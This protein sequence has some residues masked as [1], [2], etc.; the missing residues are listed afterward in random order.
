MKKNKFIHV[1][2]VKGQEW[3]LN[4]NKISGYKI[5][6]C[7]EGEHGCV[8]YIFLGKKKIEF[9][10]K[11]KAMYYLENYIKVVNPEYID[12]IIDN[13]WLKLESNPEEITSQKND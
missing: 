5:K 11:Y 12:E 1:M 10:D 6:V 7:S 2:D 13:D 9:S 3:F 4:P 8:G